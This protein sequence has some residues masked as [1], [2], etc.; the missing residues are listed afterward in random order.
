MEANT[1]V[2]VKTPHWNRVNPERAKE[3]NRLW[4]LANP[5]KK[6]EYRD[7]WR[8]ENRDQLLALKRAS[9]HRNK[10]KHKD[11]KRAKY[12]S[13][14]A[15]LSAERKAKYEKN[16]EAI[17]EK[18]RL[19]WAARPE[20]AKEIRQE[21]RRKNRGAYLFYGIT[22][23]CKAL[24]I[25]LDITK[26]WIQERINVGACEMTGIPFDL[27]GKR[28]KY[29]PSVDRYDPKGSYTQDNCAVIIWFLNRAFSNVDKDEALDVFEAALRKKR[30]HI[31]RGAQ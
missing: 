4:H 7:K 22:K 24:G 28:S 5:H 8:S 27:S 9:Y 20:R 10:N 26:E 11:A 13:D 29:S 23:N 30:P 3:N 25:E 2:T 14:S 18:N 16:K 21:S 1:S 31:F 19:Y 15:R 17:R 12:K 6:K